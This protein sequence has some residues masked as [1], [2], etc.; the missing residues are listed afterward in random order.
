[1][2]E[3]PAHLPEHED[4]PEEEINLLALAH[5]IVRRRRFIITWTSAATLLAVVLSLLKPNIYTAT[6]LIVPDEADKSGMSAMMAQ[7]GGL[8]SLAGGSL[9]GKT[10]GD[11]Y[12]TMLKS[13]TVRDPIID[14]FKLQDVYDQKYR[15]QVYSQLDKHTKV[16]LG[17]KDGVIK[18][19]VDD[20]DPTRAAALSNALVEELGTVAI[21]LN[22]SGSGKN[23]SYYE[24]RLAKARGELATAEE[25][26]KQFQSKNKAI[27]VTEQAKATIEGVAQLRAKLAMQEVELATLQRQFTDSSQEVK[28]TKASIAQLRGQVSVLEG[29]A[30]GSSIPSIGSVPA[31]GQEYLRL[32]R[33]FKVQE[34]LVELLTKQ[35]EVARLGEAKNIMPFQ[36]LQKAKVP[37]R[38]SK[39]KRSLIVL[40][41]M[42]S[43]LLVSL[44]WVLIQEGI[45]RMSPEDT[46]LLAD[47]KTSLKPGNLLRGENRP[48]S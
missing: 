29:S 30:S 8:A 26:L 43:S 48:S 40:L 28:T 38:K 46:A 31:L 41:T 19:S 18:I 15:S 23:R 13:E 4:A 36:V 21:R 39:P 10:M 37:E 35:Y 7:F 20:T 22:V 25:A 45:A 3:Q 16:A 12:V 32:M 9:G 11:L 6:A 5:T 2:T 47:I 24:E 44:F 34:G 33:E 17:A 27:A 14:R 1:M 42:M